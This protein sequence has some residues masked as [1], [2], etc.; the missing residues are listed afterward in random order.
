[1]LKACCLERWGWDASIHRVSDTALCRKPTCIHS[2]TYK[3]P[4]RRQAG[5]IS[6]LPGRVL[7]G[8]FWLYF[9][10]KPVRGALEVAGEMGVF[11]Y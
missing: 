4:G 1:M 6:E 8:N 11:V 3:V 9:S 10:L 2:R 7:I 5:L